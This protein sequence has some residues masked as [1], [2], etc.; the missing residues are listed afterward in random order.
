MKRLSDK[1]L[2]RFERKMANNLL[3]EFQL[4]VLYSSQNGLRRKDTTLICV[5]HSMIRAYLNFKQHF[6]N[7]SYRL[8]L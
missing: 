3:W 1:N 5:T 7:L 4:K 8:G 6:D 2:H